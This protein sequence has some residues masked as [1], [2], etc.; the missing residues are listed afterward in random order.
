M[1]FEMYMTY[2]ARHDLFQNYGSVNQ[3]GMR[4]VCHTAASIAYYMQG[5]VVFMKFDTPA[6]PKL[7]FPHAGTFVYNKE[8]DDDFDDL[9][10]SSN[11]NNTQWACEAT[12]WADELGA[13][14]HNEGNVKFEHG[15]D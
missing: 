6:F 2:L 13:L 7:M 14:W 3:H 5:D 9:F 1:H 8:E 10:L 12:I 4:K 11:S 15:H